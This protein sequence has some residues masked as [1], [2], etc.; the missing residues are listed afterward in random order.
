MM[1]ADEE[2]VR[3]GQNIKDPGTLCGQGLSAMAADEMRLPISTPVTIV[4]ID[5]HAGIG[6]AGID[7][8]ALHNLLSG[9]LV[10][11]PAP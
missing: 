3:I 11:L 8:G 6:T 2:F 10:L 4:M 7:N 9:F 5:A 1:L